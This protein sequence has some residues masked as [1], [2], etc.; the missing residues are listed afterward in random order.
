[1]VNGGSGYTEPPAV[2]ITG[3]GGDGAQV[4]AQIT[5]GSVTGFTILNSGQG[6]TS[7][8]TVEIAPPTQQAR[9]DAAA[10]P[11]QDGL[12]LTAQV[13]PFA[14]YQLETSP[15]MITWTAYGE[16]FTAQSNAVTQQLPITDNTRFF[17]VEKMP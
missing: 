15:D 16:P 7:L 14:T 12:T 1:L 11:S 3:G 13:A 5:D 9:L 17:R 6:Y 10:T 4:V 2:T 8:P